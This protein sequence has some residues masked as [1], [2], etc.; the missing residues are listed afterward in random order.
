METAMGRI[1]DVDPE[2]PKEICPRCKGKRYE[3]AFLA[4]EPE[5]EAC[6]LCEGEGL[7]PVAP[8]EEENEWED[9]Q[10]DGDLYP[11]HPDD[12]CRV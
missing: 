2:T 8:E 11:R 4:D 9:D 6:P 3:Y 5:K 10:Y 12:P 7:I 1:W